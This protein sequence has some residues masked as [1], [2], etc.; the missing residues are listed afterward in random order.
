MWREGG[1]DSTKSLQPS[2]DEWCLDPGLL[3]HAKGILR[4][5]DCGN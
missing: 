5:A 3:A 1:G 2:G 4:T